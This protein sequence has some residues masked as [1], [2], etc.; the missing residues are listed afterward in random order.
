MK[1]RNIIEQVDKWYF[2]FLG[3]F[4]FMNISI[5]SHIQQSL[6]IVMPQWKSILISWK[7]VITYSSNKLGHNCSGDGLHYLSRYLYTV[8]LVNENQIHCR[9]RLKNILFWQAKIRYFCVA[10]IILC[11]LGNSKCVCK[12]IGGGGI[13]TFIPNMQNTALWLTLDNSKTTKSF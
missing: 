3:F 4:I 13:L 11:V 5:P 8:S 10:G 6:T 12:M 7:Y 9:P 1:L 2:S